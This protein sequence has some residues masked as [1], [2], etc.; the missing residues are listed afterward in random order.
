MDAWIEELAAELG[1]DALTR[2]E[3]N[4]LLEAA[5]AVAHRVERRITPLAAFL[6]GTAVGRAEASGMDRPRA[7]DGA[8]STLDRVLPAEE[9]ASEVAANEAEDIAGPREAGAAPPTPLPGDPGGD[10]R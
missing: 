2:E 6:L 9:T 5:R 1:E 3:V 4:R 8:F 7:L 10:E